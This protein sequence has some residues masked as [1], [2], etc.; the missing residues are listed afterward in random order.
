MDFEQLKKCTDRVRENVEKVIVGKK[1]VIEMVLAALLAGGHVLLEDV[2]GTGKTMMA[3]ALARSI[4]TDFK[5][6][7]FTPD[8]LPSDLIGINYY[9]QKT[10]EFVF[11]QGALFTNILL[12]DEINRAT[13]RTQSSLLES[14]EEHQITV[15]GTTYHLESPFFVIATQN[16]VETQGTFP[17]PEAQLDRFLVQLSMGYTEKEDTLEILRRF[18]A[19]SPIEEVSEVCSREELLQ[20]QELVK[21]VYIHPDIAAYTV[22]IV[23]KTRVREDVALGASPRGNLAYL[24]CAQAL[25]AIRGRK[26][27]TC[28]DIKDLAL[29]VLGHRL[30]LQGGLRN[31]SSQIEHI[32]SEILDTV[33]APTEDWKTE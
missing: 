33:A 7:Q 9:N 3:K 24:R 12:A 17:L 14:M 26:Y 6:I 25:A 22:D 20:M 19:Q 8:L 15:D 1:N 28:E 4:G 16:P 18:V 11:R 10:S 31:R 13:P 30:I 32:I 2:P 29:P 27:V 21:S 5:R 23:E